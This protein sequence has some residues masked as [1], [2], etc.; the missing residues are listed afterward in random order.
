MA[1]MI[2]KQPNGLYAIWS[3]VVDGFVMLDATPQDIIDDRVKDYR[4]ESEKD[5]KR[6]IEQL[7]A[8]EK[9]YFQFTKTYDEA[10]AEHKQRHGEIE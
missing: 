3:T 5:V 7:D 9:P 8:G 2:I 1:R 10:L 6:V 4:E